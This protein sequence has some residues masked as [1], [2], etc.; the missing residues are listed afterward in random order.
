MA[1]H[2][3]VYVP[4]KTFDDIVYCFWKSRNGNNIRC[5]A[6]IVDIVITADVWRIS[7]LLRFEVLSKKFYAR[8]LQQ[9]SSCL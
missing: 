9:R 1:V 8:K 5:I 2:Q 4:T 6:Y 3:R 7:P